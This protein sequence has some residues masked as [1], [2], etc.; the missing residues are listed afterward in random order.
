M[1]IEAQPPPRRAR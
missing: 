1:R